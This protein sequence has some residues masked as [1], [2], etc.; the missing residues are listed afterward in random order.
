[1]PEH[2]APGV[3]V[4][5]ATLRD[6]HI[7]PAPTTLTMFIGLAPEGADTAAGIVHDWDGFTRIYG[8]ANHVIVDGEATPN[9]LAHAAWTF[10]LNG[11]RELLVVPL[12]RAEEAEPQPADYA[13][14]LEGS[15]GFADVCLV[16]APGASTWRQRESIEDLLLAHVEQQDGRFLVLDPPMSQDIDQIRA[17]RARLD[18]THAALYYP[19]VLATD[20]LERRPEAKI[21]LPPGGFACGIHVRNAIT[22]GVYR[23]PANLGLLGALDLEIRLDTPRQELL[24]PEGINC[25]RFFEGSGFKVWGARTISSDPE[26]KY[27][28][29]RRFMDYLERSLLR[30]TRWVALEPH[31]EALWAR[32]RNSVEAFLQREWRQGTLSGSEPEQAWFVRCDRS[33]MTREDLD[34]GRLVCLVGVAPVTP[35]EFIVL[36]ISHGTADAA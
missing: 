3:Y 30:G 23:A 22:R 17:V 15:L 20:A 4:E 19:W 21:L 7:E 1:M 32:V 34:Q 14:A 24:N 12:G 25:L 36:R 29:V 35:A 13:A 18:S 31:T 6:T 33:T 2:R 28:S 26:W 10:Y 27:I 16:Y 5:E 9:L 8:D 11:G